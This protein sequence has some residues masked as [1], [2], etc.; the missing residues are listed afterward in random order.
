M[1][2]VADRDTEDWTQPGVDT[3]VRAAAPSGDASGIVLMHDGGE[4][5]AQTVAALDKMIDQLTAWG[6]RFVTVSEG[7]GQ[8]RASMTVPVDTRSRIAGN[9]LVLAFR[10]S[11]LIRAYLALSLIPLSALAILRSVITIT[12]ARRY[13]RSIYWLSTRCSAETGGSTPHSGC[14][15]A[16]SSPPPP[17]RSASKGNPLRPLWALPF[18]MFVYRQLMYLVVIQSV[19]TAARG[20]PLRWQRMIRQGTATQSLDEIPGPKPPAIHGVPT[21]VSSNGPAMPV[22]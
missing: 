20:T 1:T 15:T 6:Y 9:A 17:L 3:L 21:P 11:G 4:H 13:I 10:I 19:V 7:L 8:T 12:A 22:S 14:S 16:S 2:V 5:R 18:Q